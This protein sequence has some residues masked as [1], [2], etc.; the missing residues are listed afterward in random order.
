MAEAEPASGD[1]VV[2][3]AEGDMHGYHA[4]PRRP[5]GAVV[6]LHEAWGVTPYTVEVVDRL[7][8]AGWE[9]IA[10]DL[11]HRDREPHPIPY[12]QLDRLLPAIERMTDDQVLAD[13]AAAQQVLISE[14][15]AEEQLGILGFCLGG[16]FSYLV[17]A[18][19]S[20]GAAIS[21]YPGGIVTASFPNL[22]PLLAQ[23]A[24]LQTPWLGLFGDEDTT[25]PIA[26]VEALREAV[27]EAEVPASVVRYPEA[28]HAFHNDR[29]D[30]FVPAA[31]EDAWD[32][33]LTWLD[34]HVGRG[35]ASDQ[36]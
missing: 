10:I 3:T 32:R 34:R 27:A 33:A 6:V 31:A 29:R 9:A 25:I 21:F 13:V 12:G 20:L 30:S 36:R 19:T 7:A 22:P 23:A 15:W 16:R 11:L 26:D 18:T 4:R 2:P 28:G 35:A 1:V 8:A 14:G 24:Q 5:R 17:A